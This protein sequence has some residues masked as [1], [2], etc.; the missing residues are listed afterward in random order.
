MATKRQRPNGTWEFIIRRKGILPKPLSITFDKVED[1]EAYCAKVEA[2]LDQ[3]I[4]P[5]EFADKAGRDSLDTIRVLLTEYRRANVLAKTDVGMVDAVDSRFGDER[6][7]GI[8]YAWAENYVARLKRDYGLSPSTVRKYVGTL[9]RAFD[10]AGRRGLPQFAVNPLRMLPKRYSAYSDDDKKGAEANG[11]TPK[12]TDTERDR[13]LMPAAGGVASEEDR[14][15]KIMA[16]EKPEGRERPLKMKYRA[17]FEC[18]FDLSLETAM[19]MREMYTLTVDQLDFDQRTIF[20][21]R[22]KNG[23]KRQVPMTTV[24]VRVLTDYLRR[25]KDGD[26]GMDGFEI[27]EGGRL[28]PWWDGSLDHDDLEAVSNRLSKSWTRIFT[29][30]GCD[31]LNFHDMRHEATSRIFERTKMDIVSISRITGHKDPRML[32]RYSNLRGADLADKMW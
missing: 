21:D 23:D 27:G 12:A 1:G 8:D 30:A 25:A 19:R 5:A 31:D 9:A 2:L 24:A 22:T 32:R 3:G 10:W 20:L 29:A 17:A 28:F 13:R 16:G 7:T 15:R 18:V 6:L 4:V 14:I 11:K 26:A